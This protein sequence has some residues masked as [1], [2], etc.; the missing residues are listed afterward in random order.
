[1]PFYK[2]RTII[3]IQ[4]E[5]IRSISNAPIILATTT[6]PND[7][8]LVA[9]AEQLGLL[10]FRGS[11]TDVLQRFVDTANQYNLSTLCRVCGD[12][13]FLSKNLLSFQQELFLTDS[14]DY[15]SYIWPDGTPAMLSHLG[16]FAEFL[17]LRSLKHVHQNTTDL[18]YR[19]HVTNYIYDHPSVIN[20]SF[21]T[22]PGDFHAF[23]NIRLTIDTKEDF[24]LVSMLYSKFI[25]SDHTLVSFLNNINNDQETIGMML[26][27]IMRNEK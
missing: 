6:S 24:D 10:V 27:Q 23:R 26:K 22:I 5:T 2:G 1:M 25:H 7:D 19:E 8:A 4:V 16:L 20:P 15:L 14:T 18:K 12:N 9:L 3:D 13:P 21:I 17:S 11:E